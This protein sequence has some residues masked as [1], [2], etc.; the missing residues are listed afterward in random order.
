[1]NLPLPSLL[2]VAWARFGF[3]AALA[4][5]LG[6]CA[7]LSGLPGAPDRTPLFHAKNFSGEA[8]MP[9]AVRRVVVLPVSGG[10]VVGQEVVAT[11]DPVVRTALQEQTRFE[12]VALTREEC[13]ARFG[14]PDFSSAAALP[15][16]FLGRVAHAFAADA[17]LFVDLTVYDP[18][19]PLQVGFRAKLAAVEDVRLIWSY[20]EKISTADPAVESSLRRIYHA[21][22]ATPVDLSTA[23]LQSPLRFASYAA[24]VMFQTLPPR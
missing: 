10:G 8:T 17:V 11:L 15:A 6:G 19:G 4:L 23:Y 7:V 21:P 12:V 13:R 1:M 3:V 9:A 16:E 22:G 20:D 24:Q 14:A 5:L 18:Y 2:P